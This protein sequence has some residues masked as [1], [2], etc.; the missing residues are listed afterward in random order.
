MPG[1]QRRIV[2]GYVGLWFAWASAVFALAFAVPER[3]LRYGTMLLELSLF[4][5]AAGL[6]L[7]AVVTTVIAALWGQVRAWQL[8]GIAQSVVLWVAALHV[9]RR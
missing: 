8:L 3:D 9:Q 2:T 4:G 5:V 6:A 7:V 1:S